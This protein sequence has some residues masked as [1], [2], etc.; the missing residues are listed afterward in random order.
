MVLVRQRQPRLHR[1]IQRYCFTDLFNGLTSHQ[2]RILVQ[3]YQEY[4]GILPSR[5]TLSRV[6]REIGLPQ[7]QIKRWFRGKNDDAIESKALDG[8][9]EHINRSRKLL[10][11][12]HISL[13]LAHF[14]QARL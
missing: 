8:I 1:E 7:T 13:N 4:E 6:S 11:D 9:E 3:L 14:S 2:L 12:A 5:R 10:D